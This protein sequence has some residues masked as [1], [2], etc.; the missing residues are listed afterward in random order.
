MGGEDPAAGKV[1]LAS[2]EAATGLPP[3]SLPP[4]G[5]EGLKECITN[6]KNWYWPPISNYGD[7][8]CVMTLPGLSLKRISNPMRTYT[9]VVERDPDTSLLV[10]Y[11]PGFPGAHSQAETLDE[12]QLNMREVLEMLLK[13]GEPTL[14]GEFVGTQLVS[15]AA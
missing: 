4:A 2:A 6:S 5:Q 12:L 15:V 7:A 3:E 11:V 14:E 13:D 1:A 8:L 10:G 9:V